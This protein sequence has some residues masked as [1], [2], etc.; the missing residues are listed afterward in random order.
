MAFKTTPCEKDQ[1]EEEGKGCAGGRAGWH[2]GAGDSARARSSSFG[3]IARAYT[4]ETGSSSSTKNPTHP[5]PQ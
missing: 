4:N 1:A 3:T 5:P 2:R